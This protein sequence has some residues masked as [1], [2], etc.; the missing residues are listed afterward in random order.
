MKT[1]ETLLKIIRS[2]IW[3]NDLYIGEVV[4]EEVFEEINK[5]AIIMLPSA[6][7]S[8]LCMSPEIHD[9]WKQKIIQQVSYNCRCRYAQSKLPIC[10]PY[11]ILKG[12]SAA[13]YYPNPEY[14]TLGDIDIIT[15]REDYINACSMLLD[16]GYYEITKQEEKKHGRHRSFVK[17]GI[18]VEVHFFFSLI[19][20]T[21]KA[22]ILDDLIIQNITPIHVLPDLIN[23]LVILEHI[24]QHLEQGLG[25][26]QIIDWMMYVDKCLPDDKW[27]DFMN[28][29]EQIGLKNLA[30]VAT[31]MCEMYLGLSQHDWC[32]D[33]DEN[34]C[35]QLMNYVFNCGN[36]GNKRT[37]DSDIGENAF[38]IARSPKATLR[39]LQDR[40]LVNWKATQ[41]YG[42]LRP[43]AWIYQLGRYISRGLDRENASKKIRKEF[44]AA[45][46]R[47][48]MLCRL[49]AR[50]TSNGRIMFRDGQYLKK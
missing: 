42:F 49:G 17:D 14:R 16:N 25:F 3:N 10:V 40:G 28:L 39:L 41:K 23:G 11:T 48:K 36:F 34:L 19:N 2:S 1:R 5:H 24:G 31:R 44:K 30:I 27:S 46:N 29:T 32:K 7:F 18:C 47:N 6:V 8:T 4:T 35:T 43:F 9:R 21:K 45:R 50:Q 26:R 37:S 22:Q 33:A 38:V 15:K 13:K 12:T 20:D